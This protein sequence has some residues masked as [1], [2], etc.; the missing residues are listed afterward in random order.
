MI[1]VECPW[2]D[3]P[4]T[5]DGA[6]EAFECADCAIRVEIAPPPAT[7]PIARAA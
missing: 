5:V 2:C 1:R 6:V 4:A 3:R 7:E